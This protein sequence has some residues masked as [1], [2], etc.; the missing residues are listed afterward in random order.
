[1]KSPFFPLTIKYHVSKFQV[2]IFLSSF[3]SFFFFDYKEQRQFPLAVSLRD[4]PN[5]Q[6][7]SPQGSEQAFRHHPMRI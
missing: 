7:L 2:F 1:M 3:L 4:Y 5:L 6:V